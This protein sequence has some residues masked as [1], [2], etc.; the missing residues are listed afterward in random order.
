M[1]LI[2]IRGIPGSGKST[3]ADTFHTHTHLETDMFFIQKDGEYLFNPH[4]LEKAHQW[5]KAETI[6]AIKRKE[7]IVISNTFIQ[8]WEMEEYL[9]LGKSAGYALRIIEMTTRYDSIHD[10][11]Y[12]TLNKMKN[13]FEEYSSI[14]A[15]LAPFEITYEYQPNKY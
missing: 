9:L 1:E 15:N 13:K 14:T 5:C 4:Q 2:L 6:N 11:P 8:F 3:F 7:N 12:D 10:I